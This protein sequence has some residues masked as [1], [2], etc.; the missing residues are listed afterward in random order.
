MAEERAQIVE[1]WFNQRRA[2]TQR[3]KE[4]DGGG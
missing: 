2:E 3:W 4:R 1:K